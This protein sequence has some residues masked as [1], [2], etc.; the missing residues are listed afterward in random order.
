MLWAR[1]VR[2]ISSMANEVTP[3]C[4]DLLNHFQ[5]SQ[6]TQESDQN[7]VPAQK[8][9]IGRAGD[10]VGAVAKHLDNNVGC[11]EHGGPVRENLCAL[12]NVVRVR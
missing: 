1:V 4:G 12:F 8:R 11:A 9:K 5:R 6:R 3:V 2:G 10:I 7:L